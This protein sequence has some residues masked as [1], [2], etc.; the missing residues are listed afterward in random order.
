LSFTVLATQKQK[1]KESLEDALDDKEF[2]TVWTAS[3]EEIVERVASGAQGLVLFDAEMPYLEKESF[4]EKLRKVNGHTKVVGL[5]KDPTLTDALET[6]RM[7]ADDY[8]HI[9][10][11]LRRLSKIAR[12][13]YRKWLKSQGEKE[14]YNG[15]KKRYSFDSVIGESAGMKEII[16]ISKRV[17][18]TGASPVLIR[19]ETG[20]GKELVARAIHYNGARADQPFVEINCTAIPETLLEAELFGHERGAFTD[21]KRQKKGLFELADGGTLFLDE[22]GKMSVNLQIK[23]LKAIEEKCFRRLGGTVDIRVSVNI[24]AATNTNLEEALREGTFREDL[25]F[26]LN[27]VSIEVP[28]LRDRGEDVILLARSFIGK[29]SEEYGKSVEGITDEAEE[30]LLNYAWPGNVRELKNV[31]ERAVLLG[32][33]SKVTLDSLPP[34]LRRGKRVCRSATPEGVVIPIP[35][36]GITLADAEKVLLKSVLEMTGWNKSRAARMLKISR[37]R[38]ARKIEKYSI[39]KDV[40]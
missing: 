22:I 31:V 36:A 8:I 21:A 16:R 12:E 3:E 38:L 14:P 28:P 5:T 13:A 24:M 7:G 17:V 6:L 23:L 32:T 4:L 19:G 25:Y 27:M 26:R 40:Q 18:E 37:P 2:E 30:C 15:Q 20:T 34:A 29:F 33:A 1:Y 35:S 9:P 10:S 39:E 11:E